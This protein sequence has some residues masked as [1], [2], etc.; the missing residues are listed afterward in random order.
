M[1]WAAVLVLVLMWCTQTVHAQQGQWTVLD[2]YISG[3]LPQTQYKTPTKSILVEALEAEQFT[4]STKEISK[5]IS[6][7]KQAAGIVGW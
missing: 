7:K 6:I 5:F 1:Q 4:I 2:S 3:L